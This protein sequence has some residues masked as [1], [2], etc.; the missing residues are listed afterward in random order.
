[1]ATDPILFDDYKV[2]Q[3]GVG[4]GESAPEVIELTG[5]AV[6]SKAQ[7]AEDSTGFYTYTSLPTHYYL[8]YGNDYEVGVAWITPAGN[9]GNPY[10]VPVLERGLEASGVSYTTMPANTL[11]EIPQGETCKVSFAPPPH[12]RHLAQ[13]QLYWSQWP[14]PNIEETVRFDIVD[15]DEEEQWVSNQYGFRLHSGKPAAKVYAH[16]VWDDDYSGTFRRLAIQVYDTVNESVDYEWENVLPV[17]VVGDLEFTQSIESEIIP[18]W[19][20]DFLFTRNS[21][22]VIRVVAEH[23]CDYQHGFWEGILTVE[24]YG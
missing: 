3:F 9:W 16:V 14:E 10:G 12:R 19:F 5:D 15:V 6:N 21:D 7:R 23:D 4:V 18:S 22:Y 13:A 1:M 11:L 24:Y 2:F 20:G 17:D 8:E